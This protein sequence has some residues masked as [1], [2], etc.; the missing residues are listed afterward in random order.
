MALLLEAVDV[1]AGTDWRWL[2]SDEG[3]GAVLAD[4]RVSL[5]PDSSEVA[6]FTDLHRYARSYAAP[7]RRL[8]DEARIVANAAEWAGQELLG[9]TIT[10]AIVEVAPVTVRVLVPGPLAPVL[11]WPLELANASG[12]PLAARGDVTFVYDVGEGSHGQRKLVGDG[13]LRILAVFSQP[14]Q[15]SV[16]ALRR[17]RFALSRLI[18]R[19]AAKERALIE[20]HVVQYGVTR[21]RLAEITNAGEGWDVLHLSGHGFGSAFLLEKA[22]GSPDVVAT[23]DLVALLRPARSRVKLAVLS[24]CDTAMNTTAETLRLL[25]LAEQAQAL[26][27]QARAIHLDTSMITVSSHALI[28]PA[29]AEVRG[30][31]RGLVRELDCAVVA[32]R[33]P[34]AD[35]FAIAFA[36]VLYEQLLGRRQPVDVAVA[37]AVADA[38]S[39]P[40]AERPPTSLATPGVFGARAVGLR[41]AVQRGPR[42]MDPADSAMAHF[43]REP[44]RF[45]GRAAAMAAAS[46]ALAPGSGRAAVLL[47]GMSGAGK[48]ACALELAWRHQDSFAAAAFWQAPT[49][50]EEFSGALANLAIALE[51]QLGA[52]GFTMT[53][54]IGSAAALEAFLPRL[55]RVLEESG[56][57]LVLDNIETLLTPAGTW[58]D[59][60]WKP[61][62]ATL[63]GHDG[64]SRLILTS[65][66]VPAGLGSRVVTLPVHALSLHESVALARELPNLRTMMHADAGTAPSAGVG[67]RLVDVDRERVRRTLRVVQGHPK[68]IELA[69]AAAADRGRLDTQLTAAEAAAAGRR[70][71]AFFKEG[72]SALN[73]EQFLAVLVGWTG[74]TLAGLSASVR[75]MAEFLAYLEDGDR[76]SAVIDANWA[77]LWRRLDRPD[78]PPEPGPELAALVSAA[79]VQV[80]VL[81]AARA[82]RQTAAEAYRMH[83]AVAAAITSSSREQVKAAVDAELG[84][85]W[86]A[87]ASQATRLPDG[88]DTGMVVQAGLAAVP[89]LLR[90]EDWDDV[91]TLLES[92]VDR[93]QSPTVAHEALSALRR[94]AEATGAIRDLAVLGRVLA[95]VDRAEAERL[96]RDVLERALAERDYQVAASVAGTLAWLLVRSGR[97]PEAL[98]ITATMTDLAER[99]RLGPWS[100][101]ACHATRLQVLS[102]MGEHERLLAE[103]HA[104]R[105]RLDALPPSR[106]IDEA[107]RPWNVY[108]A[109][110]D[111]MRNS[112]AALEDW[113]TALDLNADVLASKRNRGV[114]RY[115]FAITRFNDG[116]PLIRLSRLAEAGRMLGECQAVFEE[117]A[118]ILMLA[119]VLSARAGLEA[120]LRHYQPAIELDSTALRLLYSRPDPASI[121]VSHHNVASYLFASGAADRDVLCHQLAA[122]LI[123]RLTENAHELAG[124]LREAARILRAPSNPGEALTLAAVIG[125]VEQTEGVRLAALI[126]ELCPDPEAA[127]NAFTLLLADAWEP[128]QLKSVVDDDRSLPAQPVFFADT[129]VAAVRGDSLARASLDVALPTLLAASETAPLAQ[130]VT[131]VLA[132]GD[133]AEELSGVIESLDDDDFNL[134]HYIAT[135][136]SR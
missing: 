27:A 77:D 80:E 118:D 19:L 67:P 106:D 109:V 93:D 91:S 72:N 53:G 116:V 79:L 47:H 6:C 110:M 35:E 28:E 31:A 18:R 60:R 30:L 46:S 73:P 52:Y 57:L 87:L 5:D 62:L 65:R 126:R 124:I 129:V 75:L 84:A 71:E 37:R 20:L 105:D 135:E 40:S 15:T 25:G 98:E 76:Q 49:R 130:W 78:A 90:R 42:V 92:V 127:E 50:D 88:E 39:A 107:V 10:A 13:P 14:T 89:Y 43:P 26:E 8:A 36:G 56:V 134:I 74:T 22:D 29:A 32:M 81:S 41:L 38:G 112:A 55:H 95:A 23:A 103:G 3:T 82:D 113:A 70:L 54:H 21:E 120:E 34:V 7:D 45:V 117:E 33:Y 102:M 2:L 9:P 94:V 128:D 108:E 11:M 133:L 132:G 121:A 69:D 44:E 24:A 115:E 111:T 100:V 59:P 114:G 51:T 64:E 16:L 58:R 131:R 1:A 104:L 122:A 85:F 123:Y 61:L 97:L 83:P 12:R 63:T 136:L 119:R 86:Q 66:I 48:T 17:E 4:H 101:A 125:V 96:Q 68:L 99:A